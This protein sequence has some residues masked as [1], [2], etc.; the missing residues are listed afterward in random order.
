MNL[1]QPIS[2]QFS[3][4]IHDI[5]SGMLKI[6]QFQRD[7][8]WDVKKSASLLD[9]IVKGYPVGAFIFWKTKER[10]RS[11]RNIGN[12]ELPE[13][14]EGDFVYF[15]LDGQQRI[16]SIYAALKG[17]TIERDG[18]KENFSD[19]FI[20]LEDSEDGEIVFTKRDEM[21]QSQIINL[22]TLLKGELTTLASYD[23]K[24]HKK[25]E[26]YKRRIESYNYSVIQI[27]DAPI[28]MATE[29]FSRINEGG[30]PLSIFQIMVAKTYDPDKNFDLAER[31]D[32]LVEKL[33]KVD[34]ETISNTVVLQIISLILTNE[35]KKKTIL[36]LEKEKV[37]ELWTKTTDAIENT[38]DYFRN[39]YR[40][41][42]SNLLPYDSLIVPF[43]YFFYHHPNKPVGVKQKYLEDFFWR[44]S[45][46]ER[47]S[48][49]VESKLAQDA[50][51]INKI[52]EDTLPQYDWHV[53]TSAEYILNSG[54]FSV[55]RSY[56][57]AILCI[58]AHQQPKSF[59]D[60]SLVNI[61][62]D[63]LKQANSKNYHH[64]FPKAFLKKRGEDNVKINHVL[65]ITIVDDF[66]NKQK[67]KAKAPSKY[68]DEFAKV[69]SK[70]TDTMKTHLI[71]DFDEFGIWAD[72][73]QKFLNSRA[74][75]LSQEIKKRIISN[76]N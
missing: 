40:I 28:D 31:F 32:S 29:I 41:P 6:P 66:L 48:S 35:C 15:V 68:M 44:A 45:L 72:D 52:L 65:N 24:Y 11:V 75:T 22:R 25:L 42:A 38:I 21:N 55:G 61:T 20:N 51:R 16:T 59:V 64:F 10:L 8:V 26:E 14:P 4:L 39:Y 54:W 2:K 33:A 76:K 7:F 27:N 67:I 43:A 17:A 23:K 49:A 37:I 60:D 13:V 74:K 9:S 56:I 69:N 36:S 58:Y 34:Y 73:Y 53:D 3:D 47:Y 19:M 1:P 5:E 63:W 18:R 46:S 30:K 71:Y 57:K 50:K 70:I 12:L 62:N